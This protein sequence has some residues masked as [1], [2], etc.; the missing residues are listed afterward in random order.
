MENERESD[1]R[2]RERERPEGWSKRKGERE[3]AEYAAIP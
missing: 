2:E 3:I 1:E